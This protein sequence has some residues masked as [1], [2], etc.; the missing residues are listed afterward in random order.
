[1]GLLPTLGWEYSEREVTDTFAGYNRNLKIGD[2]E[3]FHT[4]NL[5]SAYYPLLANRKKRGRVSVLTAPGGLL[6]KEKL[7][8]VD[9]GTLYYDGAATAVTGLSG[10][11]KQ[12]VSMGAYIVIFPDKRYCNTADPTDHGSLDASY[13][14]TGSVSF[15][16]CRQ[17]GSA[18]PAPAVSASEPASPANGDLWIDTSK[19]T[20]VI[21]QWASA[22]CDWIEIPTVYTKITFISCGE[23]P[24]L[25][26]ESD[27]V[28]ISGAGADAVNG[29]KVLCSLGGDE[30][31]FDYVVVAG[32]L[33]QA[34]TQSSG[35]VKIERRAPDL[36]YVVECRNRLWGCRYGDG[37]NE[38][39]CCALGD[40]K[41]WRQYMGLSTDSWTASV[42]SDGP[43][44]GAVSFMGYPMFF[45]ENRIHRVS[46]AANGAHQITD[47][48]CRGVQPGSGKSLQ[49][50]N[51]TLFYKSRSD[52]CIYQGGFPKSISE[53][54]G[55][56]PFYNAAAG[57]IGDRYYISMQD[58]GGEWSLFVYDS[59][60][61]FWMR[62][63][64]LRVRDF[65]QLGDELYAISGENELLALQG[66]VG[67]KEPYVRWQA[68]TGLMYY[69][70]PDRKYV[71]RY[72]L[73][74]Y[75][76]EG[77]EADVYLMYDSSGEWIRQ[78]RIKMKGTRT[79]TLPIR[80][81][82]C[83]HLRMKIAGKGEVRLYSIARILTTGSDV[84]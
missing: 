55:E 82:R 65:A 60:R 46:I 56:L 2:G 51:E 74:L 21:K 35:Y 43:W 58:G 10:G 70:Y 13:T 77:A 24:A 1:M 54:L 28:T 33:E 7:A 19:D 68:E 16:P 5:T 73:R 44:T 8:Y 14:S 48:A 17:D 66:T 69:Q 3:F 39:Y 49:V 31:T 18:Y 40:F 4:E 15:S 42:G 52:I 62:E 11:E 20:H 34:V 80:P 78:G 59:K 45:K 84:G 79:V 9:N 67:T 6:A 50:V 64:A 81:R 27:G 25:F 37:L 71:Q 72:N 26:K 57:A 63:D 41:N 23:I 32:L 22:S 47:T 75:M 83:D 12:L 36:D 30:N 76:E 53:P 29:D 61:G 38:I